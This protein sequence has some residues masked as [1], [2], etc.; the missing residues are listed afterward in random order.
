[1]Q[2]SH[3]ENIPKDSD[4]SN[5]LLHTRNKTSTPLPLQ[6]RLILPSDIQTDEEKRDP[7]ITGGP[8]RSR[9]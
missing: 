9:H 3:K 1:M 2:E 6:V 5:S 4:N 8:I 7:C